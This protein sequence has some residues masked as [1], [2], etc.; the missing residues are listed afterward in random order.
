MVLHDGRMPCML[1]WA[2]AYETSI[3][4]GIPRPP[5]LTRNPITYTLDSVSY[6]KV[7]DPS[8]GSL[9]DDPHCVVFDSAVGLRLLPER[10]RLAAS[11]FR[12]FEEVCGQ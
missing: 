8:I 9:P 1:R 6:T 2:L 3:A 7:F 5:V 12:V 10:L 11:T 4:D